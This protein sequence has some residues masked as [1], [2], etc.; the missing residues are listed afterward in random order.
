MTQQERDRLVALKKAD[1]KLITQKQAVRRMGVIERQV[2]RLLTKLRRQGDR[3]VIHA[4]RGRASNRKNQHEDGKNKPSRFSPKP[5]RPALGR[6]RRRSIRNS[7]TASWSAAKRRGAGWPRPGFSSPS[8][9]SRHARIRGGRATVAQ[10]SS[11][12]GR[13]PSTTGW[14]DAA[15]RFT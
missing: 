6:R 10:A 1:K 12:N 3:A 2:R 14:K 4:G 15:R 9:A 7:A 8:G 13:P 5:S 11:C